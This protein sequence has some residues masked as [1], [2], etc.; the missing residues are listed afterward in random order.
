MHPPT[1]LNPSVIL[2]NLKH[3]R[4]KKPDV[5]LRVSDIFVYVHDI[6]ACYF[7]FSA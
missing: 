4:K 1:S 3:T 2:A 7:L 5:S 6:Y